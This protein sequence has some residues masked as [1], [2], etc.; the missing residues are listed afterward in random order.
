MRTRTIRLTVFSGIRVVWT[1]ARIRCIRLSGI[2]VIQIR[3]RIRLMGYSGIRVVRAICTGARIWL[4]RIN[5]VWLVWV[6]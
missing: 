6:G 3:D 1:R 2:R 4:T 5:S